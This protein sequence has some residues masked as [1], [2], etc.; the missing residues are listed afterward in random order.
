MSEHLERQRRFYGERPHEHLQAHGDD[1]YARK[2]A[3]RLAEAA[4]IRAHHRVLELG[5]GFGRFTFDLLEHCDSLVALDLSARA[6]AFL[7][8]TRDDRGIDPDRCRVHCADLSTVSKESVG[9]FERIVGFFILHHLADFARAIESLTS[10]L[11]AEGRMGFL[12]PN[13][14]NPLFV[15]QVV[16]CRDMTWREEKGM[17]QLSARGV[18]SAYRRAGLHALPARTFGFFPPQI[19]N[20]LSWAATLEERLERT[21]LLR[22][23]LPFLLVCARAPLQSACTD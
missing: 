19:L 11:A 9:E 1:V 2:L 21:A 3:A 10:L 18:E 7:E 5:A 20:R 17:F 22:P 8:Q 12:E 13:R 23:M 6:L 15:A 4:D 16:C 14:R